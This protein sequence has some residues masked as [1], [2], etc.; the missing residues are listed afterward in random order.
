MTRL[1]NLLLVVGQRSFQENLRTEKKKN[2]VSFHSHNAVSAAC[3]SL[4]PQA[5]EKAGMSTAQAQHFLEKI[6]TEQVKNKLR[7]T[8]D[9]ACKYGVSNYRCIPR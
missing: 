3:S 9:A 2:R 1:D 5:A 7:E 8:T 4:S 6:S